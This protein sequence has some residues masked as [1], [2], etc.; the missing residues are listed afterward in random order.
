MKYTTETLYNQKHAVCFKH[1]RRLN[2][3]LCPQVGSAL[4]IFSG[5][6]HT[7]TRNMITERH[8]LASM[9]HDLQNHQQERI[10]RILLCL[11]GYRWQQRPAKQETRYSWNQKYTKVALSTPI[12]RKKTGL[13]LAVQM[14]YWL[15]PSPQKSESNRLA[16][17][18]GGFLGVA[19][20]NWGRTGAPQQHRQP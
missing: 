19:R 4:H 14:L 20:G 3:P 16:M 15:V 9:K 11:R 18:G 12:L 10:P 8:N 1:S 17:K 6:Q 13:P 7:Q 2:Y 5:C